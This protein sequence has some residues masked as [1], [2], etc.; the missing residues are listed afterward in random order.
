MSDASGGDRKNDIFLFEKSLYQ[1]PVMK[2]PEKSGP[3]II[4]MLW[5]ITPQRVK[6]M[7]RISN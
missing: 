7:R 6:S 2:I 3:F 5:D 4:F 1:W